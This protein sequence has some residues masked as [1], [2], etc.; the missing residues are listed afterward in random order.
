MA[1]LGRRP[2]SA[3]NQ[4]F[5]NLKNN[6]GLDRPNDGAGYA[7]FGKVI[8]GMDVV[9]KIREVKTSVVGSHGNVPIDPVIIEQV[10]KVDAPK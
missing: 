7:V 1:R 6:D 8:K 5:I 9:D 4:F 10:T 3:T 2:D